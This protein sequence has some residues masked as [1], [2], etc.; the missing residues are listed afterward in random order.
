MNTLNKTHLAAIIR[1]FFSEIIFL[2]DIKTNVYF[3]CFFDFNV[4]VS[5]YFLKI[6]DT[7]S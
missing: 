1:L 4:F 5:E 3:F 7:K 6:Q 2:F